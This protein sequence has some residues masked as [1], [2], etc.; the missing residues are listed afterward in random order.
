MIVSRTAAAPGKS[1]FLKTGRSGCRELQLRE[2][3]INDKTMMSNLFMVGKSFMG[4]LKDI[5]LLILNGH[6]NK[7]RLRRVM[8]H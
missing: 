3:R 8:R 5:T 4:T 2:R 6:F 1:P 7:N